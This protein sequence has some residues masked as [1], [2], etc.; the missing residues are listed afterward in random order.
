MQRRRLF[1][2]LTLACFRLHSVDSFLCVHDFMCSQPINQPTNQPTYRTLTDLAAQQ[3]SDGICHACRDPV[4]G[5]HCAIALQ[6]LA[7]H[8][9][10]AS[11]LQRLCGRCLGVDNHVAVCDPVR[12]PTVILPRFWSNMPPAEQKAALGGGGGA[13]Q[14][15]EAS[16][17]RQPVSTA[18]S[19]LDCPVVYRRVKAWAGIVEAQ[20]L[21]D[22]LGLLPK[23]RGLV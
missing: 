4:N 18:C 22:N 11:A 12:P 10:S 15:S 3:S 14:W 21:C 20:E 13:R 1:V 19:S 2:W 5:T 23:P 7:A 8:Q 9:R 16:A 17:P 6:R